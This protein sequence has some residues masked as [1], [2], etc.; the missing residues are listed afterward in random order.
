MDERPNPEAH[1]GTTETV[2]VAAL[3]SGMSLLRAID[4]FH[5]RVDTDEPQHL[6]VIWGWTHGLLQYRDVF[7]NH[8]P[9]FHLLYAPVLMLVGE[10]ANTRAWS[11]PCCGSPP[12]TI[13]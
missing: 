12:R 8:A 13:S 3:L 9:L 5:Y 7:D 4:A 11:P 1:L 2:V 10:R 6:H